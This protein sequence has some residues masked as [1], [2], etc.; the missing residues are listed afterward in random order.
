M[1]LDTAFFATTFVASMLVIAYAQTP[2]APAPQAPA[3]PAAPAGGP[4][5]GRAAG[6]G[7]PQAV[8]P[9]QQRPPGDPARIARG[10]ALYGINCTSCHGVDLRGGDQGGPNL[11]RSQVVLSDQD[12]ELILPIVHGSRQAQGMDPIN[13][14]DDDVRAVAEYIHSVAATIRNQG[15]PPTTG[16]AVT[17]VLV[18]DAAAGQAYFAA[19][20]SGC[21]SATGDL[22]GLATRVPD[23]KALQNL[24]VS[25]G[26]GRGGG[27]RGGAAG[28]GV[29][30]RAV[31]A[32][33]TLPGG[34][35]IE[36]RLVRADDFLVTLRLADNTTRSFRRDGDKP[37]V[38]IRDPLQAHRDLLAVYTDKDMHDVTAYLATLKKP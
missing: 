1:K 20:C 7:N 32:V 16:V 13:I 17:N 10:K 23:A 21:H 2:P 5:Q 18:G 24:W 30:R 38:E 27:R 11:L 34:E 15:M 3:P 19:K 14:S 29:D 22:Q 35:K 4:A 8:F 33:V 28:T 36:G 12:G 9:A 37:K 31:V 25:G 6:D 26:S